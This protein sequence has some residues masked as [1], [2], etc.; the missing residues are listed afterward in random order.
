VLKHYLLISVFIG[1]LL[2]PM[3]AFSQNRIL[4]VDSYHAGY[5]W[6]DGI[7]EGIQSILK[8]TNV[9]LKIIRMDTKRNASDSFKRKAALE[10]KAVIESFQPDV[11]IASD[12]NA[13]K[14]LIQPYYKNAQ[15]PFVF[16]G[17]NNS[18]DAYGYPYRNVTGMIEV[19]PAPKLIYSL[20]HFNRTEKIALLIGD[21][22]TDHKDADNYDKVIDLPLDSIHVKN[23]EQWKKEYIRIQ[24]AYDILLV[25]NNGS[26]KGWNEDDALRLIMA[27]TKIPSGCDL[28]FMTPYT[29][30]GYTKSAQEQGRWAAQA[31]L[32][33]INGTSAS[34][35]PVSQNVEGNLIVNLKIAKAAGF[36]VPRSFLRK[37]VRVIE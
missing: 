2:F 6:S 17:V 24:S 30:L 16:C 23:F 10:A 28:D 33:I 14:Y 36:K 37:A 27:E 21:S 32:K 13:S 15:L 7:T 3:S 5:G 4:Y 9:K 35:I 20:K 31:A 8:D 29:F 11:V 22:L 12:D 19:T 1:F 26:I 25:G 18:G 34:D